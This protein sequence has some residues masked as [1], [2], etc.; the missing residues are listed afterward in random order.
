MFGYLSREEMLS[1]IG[2]PGS[3]WVS[4]RDIYY[5]GCYTTLGR[6]CRRSSVYT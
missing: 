1:V 2:N 4:Q 6:E 5:W 3:T